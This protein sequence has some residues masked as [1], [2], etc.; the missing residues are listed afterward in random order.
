M[1]IL[2]NNTTRVIVQG[3]T[4]REGSFH[5]ERML[6]TGT[7]IVA[8]VT[9][10]KGGS[11]VLGEKVP[12]FDTMQA[13]MEVTEADVSI[14]FVPARQATDALFEAA[15]A[16]VGMVICITEGI[17]LLDVS[18]ACRYMESKNVRLVG[19]NC[20]GIFNP[21]GVNLGLAPADCAIPGNIGVI[22]RSGT[23]GFYVMNE[24]KKLG[25]G[26]STC[27]G[28]GGDLI[29]GTSFTDALEL[30]DT[31]PYTERVL[32]IGEIGGLEE[33]RAARYAAY[34]MSKPVSA[35]LVGNSAPMGKKMGHSGAFIEGGI[36]TIQAKTEALEVS[37]VRVT[38][39]IDNIGEILKG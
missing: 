4:G 11:W 31:D 23:L 38:T 5:A 39:H 14:L 1:S 9:P 27:I 24:M 28:I 17:P 35:F 8:G 29:Q 7:Q 13:A 37:G 21:G 32:M 30:F 10:G 22:S 33:E 36:G 18:K 20:S 15:D 16:G 2:I 3:I 19:P 34:K 6:E 12:V 25:L 26:V